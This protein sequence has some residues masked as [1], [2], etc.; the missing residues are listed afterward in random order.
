MHHLVAYYTN[1]LAQDAS[2]VALGTVNDTV[3][4][5]ANSAYQALDDWRV[6]AAYAGNDA[7]TD[8]YLNAPSLRRMFLPS[9][10]PVSNTPLPANDPPIITFGNAGPMIERT[11]GFGVNA[12][13]GAVVASDAYALLWVGKGIAPIS[14]MPI[15]TIRCTASVVTS[16]GN[17]T[18]GQLTFGQTLPAGKYALVGAEVYGTN[19]LAARFVFSE[20]QLRPGVLCQGAVGEWN[21]N[22]FRAGNFG[23]FGEFWNTSPPSIDIFGVGATTTQTVFLDLQKIGSAY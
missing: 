2:G 4:Y 10:M 15:Y 6:L 9:L 21:R 11:E 20:S 12:S 19:A 5:A 8:V 1:N 14:A 3:L 18:N 23:K 16:E 17:W 7:F 13:R 22:T